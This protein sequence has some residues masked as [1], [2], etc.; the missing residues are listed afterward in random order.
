MARR[1]DALLRETIALPPAQRREFIR[2]LRV[3]LRPDELE[4]S[5]D[6]AWLTEIESRIAAF[7]ADRM[8]ARPAQLSIATIR[9]SLLRP[10]RRAR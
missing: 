8:P 2:R 7:E 3:T 4:E 9:R 5:A 1:I 10:S 6:L